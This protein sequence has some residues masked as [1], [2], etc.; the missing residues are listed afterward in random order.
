ML[1]PAPI[2]FPIPG[3]NLPVRGF[4]VTV[5]TEEAELFHAD[6]HHWLDT[7]YLLTH[8]NQIEIMGP[9]L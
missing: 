5:R 4:A 6:L 2:L 8:I 1:T 7:F 3:S 9:K